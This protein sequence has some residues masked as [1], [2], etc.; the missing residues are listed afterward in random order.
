MRNVVSA[1]CPLCGSEFKPV[2]NRYGVQQFCGAC[3][4]AYGRTKGCRNKLSGQSLAVCPICGKAFEK[5]GGRKYCSLKCRQKARSST[6][7][8]RQNRRQIARSHYQ[9]HAEEVKRKRKQYRDANREKVTSAVKRWKLNNPDKVAKQSNGYRQ[10]RAERLA[11]QA[12][13]TFSTQAGQKIMKEEGERTHCP[14]CGTAL[15]PGWSKTATNRRPD[16]MDPIALGG[17]HGPANILACCHDCN[18]RKAA[19][20]FDEWLLTLSPQHAKRAEAIYRKRLGKVPG[21]LSLGM[22]VPQEPKRKRID[23]EKEAR[24][25]WRRWLH[26][27]APDWWLDVYYRETGRPWIDHRLTKSARTVVRYRHDAQYRRNKLNR[28][29]QRRR[30]FGRERQGP[31]RMINVGSQQSLRL[32]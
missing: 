16:H 28:K 23:G 2:R 5:S 10:K 32:G 25:A 19:R 30:A 27:L 17:L 18:A 7:E 3:L 24:K 29:T 9:R 15:M 26:E 21:Q 13:G 14:Y 22:A 31:T 8:K 1:L 11:A 4:S 6:E 20:P 12:D